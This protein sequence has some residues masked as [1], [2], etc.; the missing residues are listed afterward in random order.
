MT[1][2]VT[3]TIFGAFVLGALVCGTVFATVEYFRGKPAYDG[4]AVVAAWTYALGAQPGDAL[5]RRTRIDMIER[6]ALLR[7]PWC[8][9]VLHAAQAEERDDSVQR[10]IRDALNALS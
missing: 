7:E 6:L 10:A 3:L 8:I 5:T 9:D 1:S 2:S 4:D